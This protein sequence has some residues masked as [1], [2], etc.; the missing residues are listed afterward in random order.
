LSEELAAIQAELIALN[1]QLV[2]VSEHRSRLMVLLTERSKE[3]ADLTAELVRTKTD[4][5]RHLEEAQSSARQLRR[6]NE[7]L[8]ELSSAK[9]SLSTEQSQ[10]HDELDALRWEVTSAR[11][12]VSTA[13][14][15][16]SNLEAELHRVRQEFDAVRRT[17]EAK[18]LA[19]EQERDQLKMTVSGLSLEIQ[20]EHQ[21]ARIL[22]RRWVQAE[23]VA[24]VQGSTP[25]PNAEGVSIDYRLAR[26][27]ALEL[28][29]EELRDER[30]RM[31]A[32]LR[33]L[34][35]EAGASVELEKVQ[36][37][38]R[39]LQVDRQLLE[40]KLESA[41][42]RE[43]ERLSLQDREKELKQQVRETEALRAEVERLRSKLYKTP[44]AP[45]VLTTILRNENSCGDESALHM[46]Y[47]KLAEFGEG[48]D[49]QSVVVAESAGFPVATIGN[50]VDG[51]SLAAVAGEADR[52][53]TH[54]HQL[55]GL[56]EVTK[57]TLE[58]REGMFAQFRYF[59]SDDD[60]MSIVTLGPQVA[61]KTELER[62]VTQIR[63]NLNSRRIGANTESQPAPGTRPSGTVPRLSGVQALHGISSMGKVESR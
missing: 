27:E 53:R 11:E 37:E 24:Q 61:E 34:E 12:A 49:A 52:L 29:L 54:A 30:A 19:W 59:A 2:G 28:E 56:S 10:L 51:D 20:N 41:E 43:E 16:H 60:L 45:S 5:L 17:L 15:N 57:L 36:Q 8:A 13:E 46:L 44:H 50:A 23:P 35:R 32:R 38:L 63:Q 7:R 18:T 22:E 14:S 21:A 58:D 47:R 3:I 1:Q 26:S 39:N 31:S 4:G 9:Q 33:E 48:I 40:R 62:I 55:L 6:A 25:S 42:R